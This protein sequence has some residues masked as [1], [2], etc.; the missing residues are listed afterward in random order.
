MTGVKSSCSSLG[1][2]KDKKNQIEN[3]F[4]S[5]QSQIKCSDCTCKSTFG[6]FEATLRDFSKSIHYMA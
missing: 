1:P 6:N 3:V 4:V 5:E 2:R